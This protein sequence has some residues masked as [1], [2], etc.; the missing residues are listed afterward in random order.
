MTFCVKNPSTVVGQIVSNVLLLKA[1]SLL[2]GT[3][4]PDIGLYFRFWKFKL[5]LSKE[6]LMVFTFFSFL[7]SWD[8]QKLLFNLLVWE[9]LLIMQTLPKTVPES[10][11]QL[12]DF[13]IRTLVGFRKPL[14]YCE[15]GFRKLL[16]KATSVFQ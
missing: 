4:S 2:K 9:T 8:F 14:V 10:M 16:H 12:T 13:A 15:S 11:F 3:D 1:T 7:S 6:Q 5:V